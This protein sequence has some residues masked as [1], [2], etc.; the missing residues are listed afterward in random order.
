MVDGRDLVELRRMPTNLTVPD[1]HLV[2]RV[3][4]GIGMLISENQKLKSQV[5]SLEKG[6]TNE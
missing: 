5:K 6:Q 1:K 2:N 3:I 4:H